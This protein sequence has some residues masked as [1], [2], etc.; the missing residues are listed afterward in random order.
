MIFVRRKNY[1]EVERLEKNQVTRGS[2]GTVLRTVKK[3]PWGVFAGAAAIIW[4]VITVAII[5][6]N[7]IS[8]AMIA[9][10]GSDDGLAQSGWMSALWGVDIALTVLIVAFIALFVWKTVMIK[11]A[12]SDEG[13]QTN[14]SV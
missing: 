7:I 2:D 9:S 8:G 4:S 1:S 6:V 14:E 13:G 11:R 12:K 10:A 3:L 5:A